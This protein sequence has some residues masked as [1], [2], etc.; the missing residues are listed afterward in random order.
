MAIIGLALTGL[1]VMITEYFTSTSFNPVKH[2]AAASQTGHA[3]N[4][5]AGLA[6][7]MKS[8]ALPVL[9]ICAAIGGAYCARRGRFTS[10]RSGHRTDF[11]PSRFPRWQCFP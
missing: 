9:T 2:I 8:T 4:I 5:I 10:V 11:S 1:I 7:S 6:V 3:T